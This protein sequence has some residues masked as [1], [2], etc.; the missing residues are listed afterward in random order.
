LLAYE[1]L[2]VEGRGGRDVESEE[3]MLGVTKLQLVK[4][5]AQ[6]SIWP[7]QTPIFDHCFVLAPS[8]GR[9][10]LAYAVFFS[11]F[12]ASALVLCSVFVTVCS[13]TS[14]RPLAKRASK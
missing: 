14:K 10:N 5:K 6:A 4:V 13:K 1:L 8:S 11:I 2:T 9:E 12:R 3:K 7:R